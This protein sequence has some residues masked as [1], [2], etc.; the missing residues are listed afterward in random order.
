MAK[1]NLLVVL[2]IGALI[3]ACGPSTIF[4]R[5]GLDTPS[6]HVANGH[7]LLRRGKL[8][9]ACREF[10]RAKELNPQFVK[11][12]IGLGVALTQKGD[13][14]GGLAAMDQ[15]NRL[16]NSPQEISDVQNGYKKLDEIKRNS[17][18]P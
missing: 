1:I 13:L 12:Y 15:A 5:P 11:A 7:Q 6:Q 3:A 2:S 4:V 10:K 17:A 9:D 16:A 8:D 14:S 18:S